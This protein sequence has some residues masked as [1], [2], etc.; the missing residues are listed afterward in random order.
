MHTNAYAN[1]MSS[2]KILSLMACVITAGWSSSVLADGSSLPYGGGGFVRSFDP[3]ISQYNQTG[4]LFR[5]EGNCQSAC[6]MFLAIRNVCVDL[7]ATLKFHAGRH[8]F[9]TKDMLSRYNSRL[10]NFVMA[11]HYMDTPEFHAISGSDIVA[12]FGYRECP[13]K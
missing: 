2:L 1:A 7:N 8:P 9:A 12:K 3:I 5:I 10:R 13:S 11:N 6:T 4:E